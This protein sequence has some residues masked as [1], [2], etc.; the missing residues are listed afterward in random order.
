MRSVGPAPSLGH[1]L[2]QAV[3]RMV[4][5]VADVVVHGAVA[6]ARRSAERLTAAL[7]VR[8]KAPARTEAEGARGVMTR[9]RASR[10]GA[11]PV[12]QVA[13]D[14]GEEAR[15]RVGHRLPHDA[16][17]KARVRYSRS[18]ARVIPTYARRRSS[19]SSAGSPRERMC[20]NVRPPSR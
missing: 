5:P 2:A 16:R 11:P 6:A 17:I 9:R 4:H 18:F 12:Q 1:R 10:L 13:G 14:L 8:P 3:L 19:L 20:G 15:L 7:A